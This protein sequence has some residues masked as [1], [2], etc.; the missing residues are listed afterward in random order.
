MRSYNVLQPPPHVNMAPHW[1]CAFGRTAMGRFSVIFCSSYSWKIRTLFFA[2]YC[3]G[4]AN[5]RCTDVGHSQPNRSG[6]ATNFY[7][8]WADSSLIGGHDMCRWD[9]HMLV[10][11]SRCQL[12]Y[13]AGTPAVAVICRAFAT[14]FGFSPPLAPL[15]PPIRAW[16]VRKVFPLM[17]PGLVQ[18]LLDKMCKKRAV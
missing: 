6:A 5:H 16:N 17:P 18:K 9:R 8:N 10:Q 4:P 14:I 1:R 2:R 15:K 12:E 3:W 13:G 7:K 11:G